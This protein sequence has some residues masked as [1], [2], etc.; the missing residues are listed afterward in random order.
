MMNFVETHSYI[1]CEVPSVCGELKMNLPPLFVNPYACTGM[2][3]QSVPNYKEYTKIILTI[4]EECT[5][6]FPK[7]HN[8]MRMAAI[9]LFMFMINNDR[10]QNGNVPSSLP[11]VYAMKG[12]CMSNKE[13][14][15]L[16]NTVWNSLKERSIPIL[17]ECYD[18]QWQK[19]VM[20]TEEGKPL[21]KLRLVQNIWSRIS[22]LS[23]SKLIDEM[24][25]I[26]KINLG[27][28]DLISLMRFPARSTLFDN[29]EVHRIHSGAILYHQKEDHCTK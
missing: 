4:A 5:S 1:V 28:R 3:L 15:P 13:L 10:L 6:L 2:F 23:K 9:E 26:S 7:I 24:S 25:S 18:G 19:T 8:V 21:N 27:D 14:R 11:L 16:I 20:M 22:R 29:I 17:V 12:R